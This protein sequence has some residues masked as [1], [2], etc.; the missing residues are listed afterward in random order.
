M[1][2]RGGGFSPNKGWGFIPNRGGVS[3]PIRGW[4]S[5][6]NQLTILDGAIISK[7]SFHPSNKIIVFSLNNKHKGKIF[8]VNIDGSSPAFIDTGSKYNYDPVFSPDGKTILFSS[9]SDFDELDICLLKLDTHEKY[10]LTSDHN[11]DFNPIFSP[12][13]KQIYF[14]RARWFGKYSPV[15]YPSWHDADIYSINIDGT[16]LKRI[17]W[18]NYYRISDLS[19]HPDGNALLARVWIYSEQ[20]IRK[21]TIDGNNIKGKPICPKLKDSSK[22]IDCDL[23]YNPQFSPDGKSILF[24]WKGK[25][26][27]GEPTRQLYIM[28]QITNEA[29]KITKMG[30]TVWDP[31]FS[32]D[33]TQI[34]FNTWQIKNFVREG[35]L[36]IINNDG[37]D[38][39]TIDIKE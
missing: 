1:P 23:L 30:H 18:G 35:A 36:W 19:I 6:R 20:S 2:D 5:I 33:G 16:S 25:K 7:V 29:Q 17:T 22:A 4:G 39:H 3:I 10:C 13:G 28:N 31:A 38:L 37:R 15:G 27:F 8:Q 14:L 32:V 12:D 26:F 9:S 11:H 21:F 34:V 24:T